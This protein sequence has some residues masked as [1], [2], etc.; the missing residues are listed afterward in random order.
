MSCCGNSETPEER[1]ERVAAQKRNKQL[2]QNM[3][4]QEQRENAINKLLLLGA[5][6]SGK[7]TLFKQM[8]KIYGDGF[9]K[10]ERKAFAQVI[11]NNILASAKTLS[12][13]SETHGPC[14]TEEGRAAKQ[15]L[16]N[17]VKGEENVDTN[18]ATVLAAFWSDPGI[19]KTY[20]ARAKYQLTDSTDYFLDQVELVGS[21]DYIPSEQDVLRSRVRTTG[22]VENSF[23]INCNQFK[24]Y[25]VGG[26]RN[27]RKKWIHCF[28]NVTAV[29][30]VAAI[31]EFDQVLFEDENT[32]RLVEA[33]N[34]FEEICNSR[35]FEKT[36]IILFLNKSDMFKEKIEKVELKEYFP[37]FD[38]DNTFE[39]AKE[40]L[41]DQFL[42]RNHNE[43]KQVYVQTTCATNTE[44]VTAVFNAVK[45]IIIR[46]SLADAGLV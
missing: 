44:N 42:T 45:D 30:F 35:W 2:E 31:S 12:E 40:F 10:E 7:S 9:P 21:E 28:E 20:E 38:G 24:M 17:E 23:T 4:Q 14:E 46:N 22:I 19:V 36:S 15:Y 3:N 37:E 5:G 43:G 26:Q 18:L 41:E 8:I 1:E 11:Y 27:E 13:A 16:D 6:E 29:I 25:D 34:L 32:N 39:H 33:L